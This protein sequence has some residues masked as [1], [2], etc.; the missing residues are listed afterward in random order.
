VNKDGQIGKTEFGSALQQ[1]NFAIS[2][3]DLDVLFMFIDLDGSESID[4]KEFLWKLRRAGLVI[5]N[6]GEEVVFN[7]Y[8]S[9]VNSGLSIR[10]AYIAFDQ[11]QDNSI[12]KKEMSTTFA[13]M[14]IQVTKE[15]IDYIFGLADY[16]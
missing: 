14:G 16:N 12:T 7:L 8:N 5:R 6:K 10:Q 1:M 2:N 15:D 11:N 13:S 9:I 3:R 4:Y